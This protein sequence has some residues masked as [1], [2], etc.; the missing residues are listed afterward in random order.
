[1][2][3]ES[4]EVHKRLEELFNNVVLAGETNH[5]YTIP[6]ENHLAIWI[7]NGPRFGTLQDLWPSLKKWI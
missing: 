6:Y 7:V 2:A 3:T 4:W 5:P 1:M